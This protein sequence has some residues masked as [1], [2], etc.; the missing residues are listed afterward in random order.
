VTGVRR[1]EGATL[2][3]RVLVGAVGLVIMLG[4]PTLASWLAIGTGTGIAGVGTLTAPGAPGAS[5]A[6]STVSLSWAAG[7]VSGGGTVKYHVE[8]R[9]NAGS[10]WS[11]VCGSTAAAP[12]TG[13][14]CSDTSVPSGTYRY[15]VTAVYRSWT[16]V[17]AE[18]ASPVTV[19]SDATPPTNVL[20]LASGATGAFLNGT[21]LF[22]NGNG[23]G[24]FQLK[25]AVTDSGAGATGP[26]SATFPAIAASGWTHA[27]ETVTSGTGSAPT[28]TYTSSAYSW[29]ASP[30]TPADQAIIGT[31]VAGNNATSSVHFVSDVAGPTGGALT[32]NGTVATAGGSSSFNN[33]GTFTIG[34]RTD[35]SADALSG[36]VSSVLTRETATL[37]SSDGVVDGTCGATW[38]GSTTIVGNPN[39]TL[40]NGCYR[41]TLTG[42]D[43]V[44]N[45]SNLV[46]IVKVDV[47]APTTPSLGFSSTGTNTY[48]SGSVVFDNPQ[49]GKSGAFTVTAATTDSD[50]GIGKVN[51]PSLTGITGGG[52][53]TSSPFQTTYTWSGAGATASGSQ[54]VTATNNALNTSTGTFTVT[55]DTTPP[56]GGTL[57]YTNGFVTT[58]SVPVTLPVV[59]DAGSGINTSGG[60]LTRAETA[61]ANGVCSTPTSFTTT[62]T[63]SG[64][65]DISVTSDKCYKYQYTAADNVGNVSTAYT[66]ASIA[67]VDATAPSLT[68]EQAAGQA[69][70]TNGSTINFTATFSE[71]VTLFATG[72]VTLSGTAGATT[73]TVTGTG[74]FNIAVTGMTSSG[75]VVASV[76]AN[77]AIDAAGNNNV[78]STSTDNTVTRDVTG[79]TVTSVSSTTANGSY[80][81]T[82]TIAVTVT[83]S[84]SVVVTGTPTL[85]LETGATNRTASCASG[86]GT[87]TLT[88]NYVVQAG[89]TSAD[90][91]YV[92]T[93]SLALAGGTIR[94]ALTNNATL[95]LPAPGAANSLGANKAIVID[96]A[97]P[98][99]TVDKKSG[100][101]DPTNAVPMLWTV[102]FNE[103]VTGFDATDLTRTG[104]ATGGSV[105]VTGS[106]ASYEISVSGTPTNGTI[107][108]TIAANKAIDVVGINNTA[109][110]ST[111]NTI[112]YDTVAPTPASVVAVDDGNAGQ[113]AAKNGSHQ[114]TLTF[115]YTDTN[116]MDPGSIVSGWNG[117]GLQN[118]SVVFTDGGGSANDTITVPGI[119]VVDLG[120]KSWLTSTSTKTESLS[121]LSA[122]AFVLTITTDPDGNAT[123][124]AASNFTWS[125]STGTADDRA[126]NAAAGSVTSNTQRF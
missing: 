21:T 92:A 49:A 101:A 123:G 89:D 61:L 84:E 85:T 119:G 6:A 17:G 20:S 7:A 44:G 102:T 111:D 54:T 53:D 33:T 18:S 38:T 96:T 73:A 97:A 86:T 66:S 40:G 57:T 83:F 39:Q 81:T 64:G 23:A 16:A 90:L 50:S 59:T 103:P 26:A 56:S 62:V 95:T 105:S 91:D 126:G 34:T 113:I 65:N 76:A 2:A 51:F 108:F 52:D 72:D 98:T 109:S 36:F 35:F 121:Q 25:N 88:F 120:S 43:K 75:T 5:V 78:A 1:T 100:Q 22:F 112:T 30:S 93:N 79:P 80:T 74:P 10:T 8:R 19:T 82:A 110:T 15:R 71:T 14:S 68:V 87:A 12:I 104:T 107:I 124:V 70:P 58:L 3:R 31:D 37:T 28:I 55:P 77:K 32:V 29:T 45:T 122:N 46:G 42:T 106:G 125:T 48:V 116:G 41:F 60:V 4:G 13:T 63:L 67:K 115:T 114:D 99:V 11:S 24:S 47:T 27:A 118:V 94:D 69:D 117:S 9:T